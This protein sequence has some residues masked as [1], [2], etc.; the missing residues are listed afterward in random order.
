MLYF[1]GLY[2]CNMFM[3][4]FTGPYYCNMFM[5][6]F[7]FVIVYVV[8]DFWLEANLWK[9]GRVGIPLTSLTLPY[10]C[11]C[12]KS[13]SG[14]LSAYVVIFSVFNYLRWVVLVL[15]FFLIFSWIF[16]NY[17]LNSFFI[18]LA[19]DY[20]KVILNKIYLSTDSF[21]QNMIDKDRLEVP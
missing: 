15:F 16:E 6:Y 10:F 2:Y 17:S 11:A 1:T 8:F 14:F 4:Y 20:L 9:W 13:S 21:E 19:T 7:I 12:S 18:K 3:L 5:L